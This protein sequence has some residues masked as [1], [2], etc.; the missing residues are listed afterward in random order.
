MIESIKFTI[1]RATI[2]V[3]IRSTCGWYPRDAGV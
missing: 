3:Q 2:E 1:Q